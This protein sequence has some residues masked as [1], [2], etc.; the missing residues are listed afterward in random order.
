M[1]IETENLKELKCRNKVRESRP[2]QRPT[3][4]CTPVCCGGLRW[5]AVGCV[6]LRWVAV[7]CALMLGR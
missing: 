1:G 4:R 7:G 5:V 2:T 6:G 3:H